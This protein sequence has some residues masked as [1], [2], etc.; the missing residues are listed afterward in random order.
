MGSGAC[1]FWAPAT[2]GLDD[3]CKSVVLD[4]AGDPGPAIQHAVDAC[5]T[6]AIEVEQAVGQGPTARSEAKPSEG[7]E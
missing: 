2:F 7:Q 1:Q 4:P 6:R 5:P 3:E